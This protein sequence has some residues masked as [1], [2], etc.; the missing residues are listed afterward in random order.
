MFQDASRNLTARRARQIDLK[1][2]FSGYGGGH[3]AGGMKIRYSTLPFPNFNQLVGANYKCGPTIQ[4]AL[5]SNKAHPPVS[6]FPA[7]PLFRRDPTSV[8]LS[9]TLVNCRE[10]MICRFCSRFRAIHGRFLP[11]GIST[12]RMS[13]PVM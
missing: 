10:V 5:T 13:L 6:A 7:D 3:I 12:G 11:V 4:I 8:V 9:P 1:A 2:K